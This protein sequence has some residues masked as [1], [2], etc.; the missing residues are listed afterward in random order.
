M[1]RNQQQPGRPDQLRLRHLGDMG[2]CDEPD[3]NAL[4]LVRPRRVLADVRRPRKLLHDDRPG[5]ERWGHVEPLPHQDPPDPPLRV[6]KMQKALIIAA[7][8]IMLAV[9]AG[10]LASRGQATGRPSTAP[11]STFSLAKA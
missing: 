4:R 10:Y 1:S 8:L 5:G 6:T 2:S 9:V 3:E 7:P 11:K